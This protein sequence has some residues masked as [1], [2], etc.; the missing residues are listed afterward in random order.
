MLRLTDK[1]NNIYTLWY[2]NASETKFDKSSFNKVTEIRTIKDLM[3][4][5]DSLLA[6]DNIL[7]NDLFYLMIDDIMPIWFN[8]EHINGGCISWKISKM[9]A[10]RSWEN[11]LFLFMANE[12]KELDNKYGITGISINPKKNCNILKIWFKKEIPHN[13]LNKIELPINCMFREN[14]K[15]FKRFKSFR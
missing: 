10:I 11:L 15:I 13:E 6:N 3:E 7:L 2:H 9:S 1:L 14:F 4:L 5:N 8:D 12:F